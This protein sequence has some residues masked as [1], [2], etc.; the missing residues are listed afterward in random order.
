MF[1]GSKIGTPPMQQINKSNQLAEIPDLSAYGINTE[2]LI[3]A[4]DNIVACMHDF[5]NRVV[6]ALT[7]LYNEFNRLTEH[8][9]ADK[10]TPCIVP[11]RVVYLSQHAKSWRV[12]K[13][14]QKRI[15]EA[16][17]KLMK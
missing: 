3:T 14:N 12:R 13:K 11:G 10:Y 4:I 7:P 17:G 1:T 5:T 6:G 2:E 8:L 15:N 9:C 16:W